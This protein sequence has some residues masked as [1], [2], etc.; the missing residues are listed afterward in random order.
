MPKLTQKLTLILLCLILPGCLESETKLGQNKHTYSVKRVI[1][2]DT[3]ELSNAKLVRYIGIDTPEVRR[4]IAG[5]WQYDPEPYALQASDYNKDLVEGKKVILE[6]DMEKQDKYNR[7][8]AYV[9]IDGKMAN[10]ELLKEGYAKLLV[11]PPNTKYYTRLKAAQNEAN[12]AKRGI[13]K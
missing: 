9:Y 3:V 13:W 10:E 4:K 5:A 8:L 11:I 12:E 2:G 1:D 6:F 7:W